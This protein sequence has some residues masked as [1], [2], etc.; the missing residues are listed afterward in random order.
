MEKQTGL[1]EFIQVINDRPQMAFQTL[2]FKST[3]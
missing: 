1:S 2:S 3:L